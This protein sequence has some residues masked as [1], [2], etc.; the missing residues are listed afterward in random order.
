MAGQ[1][2]RVDNVS[3]GAS[4]EESGDSS[5]DG[6]KLVGGAERDLTHKNVFL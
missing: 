4:K 1:Y 5:I 2:L 3:K 6:D